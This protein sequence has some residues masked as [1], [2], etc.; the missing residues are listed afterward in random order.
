MT[1]PRRGGTLFARIR[2]RLF[3]Y[4]HPAA[5]G[6]G[7]PKNARRAITRSTKLT[8]PSLFRSASG[9]HV[10]AFGVAKNAERKSCKSMKLTTQSSTPPS[11]DMSGSQRSP[12]ASP[13]ES[14]W[15]SL[16]TS[17]QLSKSRQGCRR[18]PRSVRLIRLLSWR[19]RRRWL[20]ARSPRARQQQAQRPQRCRYRRGIPRR[21]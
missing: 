8:V 1:R 7:G 9:S 11:P 2:A 3:V 21:P 12:I 20:R 17:M 5:L 6:P 18:A 19:R 10:G 16:A 4:S 13:L 15:S 14:N